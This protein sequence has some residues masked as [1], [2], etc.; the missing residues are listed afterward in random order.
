MKNFVSTAKTLGGC[1]QEGTLGAHE[2]EGRATEWRESAHP[3][4]RT[5][6]ANPGRLLVFLLYLLS[7]VVG[8]ARLTDQLELSLDPV[9]V[10][11]LG[12]EDVLE[13]LAAAIVA[14]TAAALDAVVQ[15]GD[16]GALEVEIDAELLGHG[17]AHVD[18]AQALHVG[19]ALEVQD[20]LDE[21]VGVAHLPDGLLAHL[22]PQPLVAPVL[23]HARMDEV[24]VDGR[25]L[26][27]EDL[28]EQRDDVVVALHEGSPRVG[29]G[30]EN[31]EE[32]AG[33]EAPRLPEAAFFELGQRLVAVGR[34][35]EGPRRAARKE[36]PEGEPAR[37]ARL[38]EGEGRHLGVGRIALDDAD[39]AR[40]IEDYRGHLPGLDELGEVPRLPR[41]PHPTCP[42]G[43]FLQD[44]VDGAGPRHPVHD[45]GGLAIGRRAAPDHEAALAELHD[46]LDMRGAMCA[47]ALPIIL[48]R[49][50]GDAADDHG[51]TQPPA[52]GTTWPM[53][54]S[55]SSEARYTA[56]RADSSLRASRPAGTCL[57]MRESF[58]GSAVREG[59][60]YVGF[61]T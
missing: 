40:A 15:C 2:L 52:K 4:S 11:L 54:K 24:L 16:R 38:D 56:S 20:A 23:A 55:A 37:S 14:E 30:L 45:V 6:T 8:F 12:D 27:G 53:K 39:L 21:P 10:L 48:G 9:D 13:Q 18:L 26:G 25:E 51:V 3:E 33:S 59:G 31:V 60:K 5:Q 46:A 35:H 49:G 34:A 36:S 19:H 7:E 44:P 57:T 43:I 1:L 22:L 58:S 41:R 28:V 29:T 61:S 47:P 50:E 42:V 17:L 32:G